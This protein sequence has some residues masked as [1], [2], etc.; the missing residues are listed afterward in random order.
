MDDQRFDSLARSLAGRRSRRALGR[1]L[2][3]GGILLAATQFRLPGVAAR[4]GMSGPGEPCRTDNQCLAADT[5]LVCAWNGFNDDGDYN[6]CTYEGGRCADDRGCCGYS[7]CAGG[8]CASSQAGASAGGGGTAISDASGGSV[9]IGDINSGGNTGNVI[10]VGGGT[11]N[12]QIS[13]GNVSNAT[14]VS[15]SADGGTAISDA[16]GGSGNVS[17]NVGGGGNGSWADCLGEWCS[18]WQ[19]Q[20]GGNPC[21]TGLLCCYQSGYNGVCLTEYTCDGFGWSGSYCPAWCDPGS[22]CSSCYSGYC[23]WDGTCA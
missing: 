6:C 2:L 13:V 23:G 7:V 1:G 21:G 16:S 4:H 12:R 20:S 18:C 3:S 8:F 17:G 10:S 22:G 14:N 15:V 9:R 19:G 5:A 11:G